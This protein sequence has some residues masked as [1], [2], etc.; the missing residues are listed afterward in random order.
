MKKILIKALVLTFTLTLIQPGQAQKKK[1]TKRGVSYDIPYQK[2]LE[3][4]S[5]GVT[6]FYNWGV[7]PIASVSDTSDTYLDYVPM[8]WNNGYDRTKLRTYLSN[9]PKVKYILGFNEPNFRAQANMTPSQA[10]AAWPELEAIADEFNLKIVAPAVNYAPNNGSVTEGN[11]TYTNPWEYLD[12]FFAAAPNARVDYIA[13]HCY[14]NDPNAMDWFVKE[15]INKY[16]KPVWLTEFCAWENSAPLNAGRAEGLPYQRSTMIRK[17]EVL[18]KNPMVEKYAWFIPRTNNEIGYPYMQLMR[19]VQ[20]DPMYEI[21]GPGVLTDLGNVYLHMSTFDSTYFAGVNQQIPAKD[22]IESFWVK[23]ETTT[24]T[25]SQIPLQLY[26]FQSGLYADYFVEVPT[27]GTYQI[28]LRMANLAGINP[29]FKISSNGTLLTTQEVPSTGGTDQWATRSFPI[30]LP[31]GKQTLRIASSGTSGCKLVWFS[32][33]DQTDLNPRQMTQCEAFIDN[34]RQLQ[35]N[36]DKK[37]SAT[38]YDCSG[39]LLINGITTQETDLS[40]VC[41]GI[42]IL[43]INFENGSQT[44]VKLLINQ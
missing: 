38:L 3:I 26:D 36:T 40:S 22:Y 34:N 32:L 30:T 17:I 11:V 1:S 8:A 28:Q 24:D 5:E 18:E 25:T 41:N 33:M 21:V 20:T 15:F 10:A 35:I 9:H 6:W 2:D 37:F 4:L 7:A 42:Y 12:A 23:L 43:K 14:M 39:R 44:S 31:A 27:A 19:S 16:H 29:K 13:V